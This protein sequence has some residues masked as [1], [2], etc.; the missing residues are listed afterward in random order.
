MASQK[1]IAANRRNAARSTGPKSPEG[2]ATVSRNATRH[3]LTSLRA[4]VLLEEN[5]QEFETFLK[6]LCAEFQPHSPFERSLVLQLASA[7]WRLRRVARFETG[8]IAYC[9]RRL[10]DDEGL[11]RPAPDPADWA[12]DRAFDQKTLM[13]GQLFY[14]NCGDDVFSK[15]LRYESSARRAYYKALNELR[16]VQSRR[17]QTNPIPPASPPPPPPPPPPAAPP[18][19]PPAGSPRAPSLPELARPGRRGV[20]VSGAESPACRARASQRLARPVILSLWTNCSP[21]KTALS[22]FAAARAAS[23]A[24]LRT[25]AI[26]AAPAS[27]SALAARR[28]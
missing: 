10:C 4:I 20:P 17:D 28:T 21:S 18:A 26:A 27:S 3:G 2:K 9:C 12:A 1:Q 15:L 16:L 8:V 19:T 14:H 22:T 13:L 24:P 25:L 6:G 5:R 23:D 11:A 7:D